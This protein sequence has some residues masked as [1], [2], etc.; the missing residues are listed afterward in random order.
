MADN[1]EPH[2]REWSPGEWEAYLPAS[3]DDCNADNRLKRVERL[4]LHIKAGADRTLCRNFVYTEEEWRS[5]CQRAGGE[6]GHG[7]IMRPGDAYKP[8]PKPQVKEQT[9]MVRFEGVYDD[10][11]F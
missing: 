4:T 11:T 7:W 5:G 8:Q 3:R 2:Y 10:I 1:W 6:P 9:E